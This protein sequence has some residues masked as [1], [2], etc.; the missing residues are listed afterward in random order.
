[1][2][3]LKG[4]FGKIATVLEY[5]FFDEDTIDERVYCAICG[6]PIQPKIQFSTKNSIVCADCFLQEL[7]LDRSKKK[8]IVTKP[9]MD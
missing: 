3:R 8:A 4:L 1:M 2:K 5:I 7:E 6:E 9:S